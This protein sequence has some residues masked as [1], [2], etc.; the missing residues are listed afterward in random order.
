MQ[1]IGALLEHE[2]ADLAG[3]AVNLEMQICEPSSQ[4]CVAGA[5]LVSLEVE[6]SW[7]VW[8]FVKLEVQISWPSRHFVSAEF[9]ALYTSK[10]RIASTLH[11]VNVDLEVQICALKIHVFFHM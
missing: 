4:N 9:V 2:C 10:C 7:Q 1:E 11:F 8:H 5:V 6:V 3:A